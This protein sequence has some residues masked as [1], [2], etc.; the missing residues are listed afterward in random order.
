[1]NL[2][3]NKPEE[4]PTK[5]V[6]YDQ[7]GRPLYIHPSSAAQTT[8]IPAL[9][10]ANPQTAPADTAV[11]QED[12]ATPASPQVVYLSRS[13]DPHKQEIPVDVQ[14]QHDESKRKYPHLDLSPGEFV[15]SAVS[16]HPIGII[17]IWAVVVLSM[18]VILVFPMLLLSSGL[19]P[20]SPTADN[21][22]SGGLVLVLVAVM[23]VLGGI[24]STIVYEANRFYLTNESVIQYI[25]NS[26]FSKKN[27]IISLGNIED[28]S[29][30]QHGIPQTILN[31]GA[32]RL[33]T[34]GEETTYRFTY[35]SNPEK[36]VRLLND[37]VEAFKN[38]RPIDP[39]EN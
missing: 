25:Q 36:Q 21:I 11:G 38:F 9:Q 14:R 22:A 20:F 29:Y 24:V 13:V 16:R 10:T 31:Y 12:K 27:Q 32:I 1:M 33:S 4:D 35:V 5:P 15:I 34:Q 39:G 26:L 17:S 6:A 23:F 8:P 3:G 30:R 28:A 7:Y 19:I 18:A 37:A 2:F